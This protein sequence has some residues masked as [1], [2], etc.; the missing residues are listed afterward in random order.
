M[1]PEWIRQTYVC[2]LKKNLRAT[3]VTVQVGENKES[4]LV[5]KK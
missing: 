5:I 1:I 3:D 4:F 2:L